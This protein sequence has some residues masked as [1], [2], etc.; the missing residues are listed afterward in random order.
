[1]KKY[2]VVLITC[3]L[4][5]SGCS[6]DEVQGVTLSRDAYD[7]LVAA[8]N[9]RDQLQEE[10]EALRVKLQAFTGT[11][12]VIDNTDESTDGSIVDEAGDKSENVLS[13]TPEA[14]VTEEANE[15]P[16]L[17]STPLASAFYLYQ[18]EYGF[19][20]YKNQ[21]GEIVIEADYDTAAEFADGAA[22]VTS[23]GKTGILTSDGKVNWL[24]VDTYETVTVK[25]HDD[26]EKG[27][28]FGD[29]IGEYMDALTNGDEA[30]IKAHTHPN[31]KI[32]FG[33][34]SGWSGLVDYW[35]LDEGSEAFYK[36]MKTT[37]S[38]GAVDTSGGMGN[39]FTSPY[40]FTD[41]PSD[42][43][44]TQYSVVTGSGVNIRKRPTTESDAFEQ[45][46]YEVLKV[47]AP[48]ED[49]WVKVQMQDGSIGYIYSQYIWSPLYYRASFTKV[50]GTW[51]LESFVKGD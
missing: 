12:S 44:A 19:Y 31:A 29:F 27:S 7:E 32:S 48:E 28:D 4:I 40:M 14:T 3:L 35:S 22:T 49:G 20:G 41:F 42:F 10:N 21:E 43:D 17:D 47:L 51:L 26:I 1:M 50:D 37:L 45:A 11:E 8:K 13:E 39:E 25:P 38:Y 34:H 46:T 5:I 9:E 2:I 6:K 33:G 15:D 36:M 24:A 18:D 16:V 30:Y 23:G